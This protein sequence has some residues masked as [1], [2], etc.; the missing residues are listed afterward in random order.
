MIVLDRTGDGRTPR[1]ARQVVLIVEEYDWFAV[2][3]E[4]QRR[5]RVGQV[6]DGR[7]YDI[8]TVATPAGEQLLYFDAT[9]MRQSA[10]RVLAAR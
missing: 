4:V 7:L 6:I 9:A 5:S 1:T 3:P 10:E 2:N 8:W